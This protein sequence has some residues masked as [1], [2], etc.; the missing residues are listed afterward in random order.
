MSRAALSVF[1][2]FLFCLP[3]AAQE[4]S[5]PVTQALAQGDLFASKRKYELALDAYHKAD[6]LSHHSSAACYLKIASVERKTGDFSSALEDAKR[7][8]KA[9]SDSKFLAT[10]AHLFRATLLSQMAGKPTD[11]KLKEAEEEIRQALAVDPT[12]AIAHYDLG[13][14]LLKQERDQEGIAEL[15]NYIGLPGADSATIAE[16]RRFIANPIRAR[17][18]FAPVFSFTTLE[19]QKLSNAALR[20]KV[21]LM[22]FWGTWCPPCRESVPMLRKLN[23]KYAGKPFQLVGVSSDNDEDVLENVYRGAAH[24]LVRIYRSAGRGTE[25]L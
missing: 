15:N 5:D 22:D 7:A 19:N 9:A 11:K 18:P 20:G 21:I 2:A 25:C 16:A 24:G 4:A 12:S 8:V 10:Q 14:V 13:F 6:K 17:A 3:V 1:L 23:K